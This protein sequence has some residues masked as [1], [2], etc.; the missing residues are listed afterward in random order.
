MRKVAITVVLPVLLA[1]PRSEFAAS[2]EANDLRLQ[3]ARAA[4]VTLGAQLSGALKAAI[5][6]GGPVAGVQVCNEQ[7]MPLT[8]LVNE[9]G[10]VHVE[11]TAL[12]VRNP[13]NTA[14]EWERAQL[15]AFEQALATGVD[16]EALEVLERVTSTDGVSTWRYMRPIMTAGVCLACHGS[17]LSPDVAAVIAERYPADQATGF[18]LGQLRGAFSVRFNDGDAP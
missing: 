17:E 14:D 18:E 2:S 5:K 7:A 4:T 10:T 13:L 9:G 8:D 6:E 11:R 12:K 1:L 16:P 3:Q 15:K